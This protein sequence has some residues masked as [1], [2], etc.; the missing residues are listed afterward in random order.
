[1]SD[2]FV[3]KKLNFDWQELNLEV[4][5][6]AHQLKW[7]DNQSSGH[8]FKSENDGRYHTGNHGTKWCHISLSAQLIDKIE[9]AAMCPV[10]RDVFYLWD[11]GRQVKNLPI[12]IDTAEINKNKI[13]AACIPL[14]GR[15]HIQ[16]YSDFAKTQAVGDCVYGPG[17]LILLNN[18]KYYHEGTVLDETRLGLHFFLDFEKDTPN[19]HLEDLLL[20]N[21]LVKRK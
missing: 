14:V 5:S 1:M 9:T 20:A 21:Q 18:R 15:F 3:L 7:L 2:V 8:E 11:Y 17:D 19:S 13:V 16:F 4:Q 6:Q 12:H 10:Y